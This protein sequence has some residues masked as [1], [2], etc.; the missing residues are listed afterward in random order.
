MVEVAGANRMMAS[1]KTSGSAESGYGISLH[2]FHC[3]TLEFQARLDELTKNL[4]SFNDCVQFEENGHIVF[5]A[6]KRES[7]IIPAHRQAATFRREP[8]KFFLDL[9]AFLART[10]AQFVDRLCL[11]GSLGSISLTLLY[12]PV[13]QVRD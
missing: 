12:R 6:L 1:V 4:Y 7:S 10:K 8:H 11:S 3:P 13:D 2:G 5:L 9:P